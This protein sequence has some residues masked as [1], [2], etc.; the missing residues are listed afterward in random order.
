MQVKV[1]SVLM[2]VI[3]IYLLSAYHVVIWL[4]KN[5]FH[6]FSI[7]LGNYWKSTNLEWSKSL[8]EL[9]TL[10]IKK[11]EQFFEKSG[12]TGKTQ[13]RADNLLYENFLDSVLC[14]HD[15]NHSYVKAICCA[16]Y[17]KSQYHELSCSFSKTSAQILYV[18]CSCKAGQ[19][20]FC[21]HVYALL[22]Y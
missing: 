1:I 18:Y 9:P 14:S 11:I 17:T 20:G 13:K 12:K 6:C 16:S 2:L 3:I 15:T 10:T 7:D 8:L 4:C 5:L 21:N 19:G 22:K